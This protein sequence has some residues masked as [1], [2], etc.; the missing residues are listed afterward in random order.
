MGKAARAIEPPVRCGRSA[1][2]RIGGAE[3]LLVL[4][5]DPPGGRVYKMHT[6]THETGQGLPGVIVIRCLF[7]C[8][9]LNAKA[10]VRAAVEERSHRSDHERRRSIDP[11]DPTSSNC[12]SNRMSAFLQKSGAKFI[13]AGA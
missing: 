9:S 4:A 8:V 2:R 7:G 13:I 5:H 10:S 3:S 12:K 11:T 6:L 1:R